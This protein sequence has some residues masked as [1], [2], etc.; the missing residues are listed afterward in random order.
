[1]ICSYLFFPLSMMMGIEL[2][3]CQEVAK[4]IGLKVFTSEMLA[5][6]E[7]GVSISKGLVSVSITLGSRPGRK[8]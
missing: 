7:L 4:L 1:M 3:E 2:A 6:Q 8:P 5:Y